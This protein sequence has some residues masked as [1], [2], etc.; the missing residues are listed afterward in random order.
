MVAVALGYPVMDGKRQGALPGRRPYIMFPQ[1][2]VAKVWTAPDDGRP[3]NTPAA[4][5]PLRGA[6]KQSRL[7]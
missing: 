3:R 5:N 7:I 6:E 2:M 1:G 4:R